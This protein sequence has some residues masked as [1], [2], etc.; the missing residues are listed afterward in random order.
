LKKK[1]MIPSAPSIP[2][3]SFRYFKGKADYPCILDIVNTCTKADGEDSVFTLESVAYNY[4]HLERCDPFTDMI[5]AEVDG[6]AVG[7]GRVTWF[8]DNQ[9]RYGYNP[10]GWIKPAWRRKGIGTAILKHNENRLAQIASQHPDGA[11]KYFQSYYNDLEIG[12]AALLKVNGYREVRWAYRMNRPTSDPLPEAQLPA[13][14]EVRPSI[15]EHFR[16]VWNALQDAFSESWGFVAGTEETYNRW[17]KDPDFNPNLWKVAWDGNEVAGMVLNFTTADDASAGLKRGWT[18]PICVRKPWRRLGVARSLLV[19]SIQMFRE[20]G[21]KET[22]L[23]V[24]TQN[25][26]QALRLYESVGYKMTRKTTVLQK[27]LTT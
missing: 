21:Y 25:P 8:Q 19:Q 23:G 14:L 20:L 10:F 3:L 12:T 7:Y 27:P 16:P 6:N 9:G 13:H 5:F 24:D 4:D 15:K 17:I 1:I 11:E 22:A 2:G 26:N 18:D